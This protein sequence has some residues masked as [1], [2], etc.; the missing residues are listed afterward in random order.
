[1]IDKSVLLQVPPERAFELF[2][3]RISAWWPPDRRH[4]GDPASTL[5]LEP[6]GRF[7][8]RGG[9]GH[10]VELG[11]VVAW[12]PPE[13]LVLDFYPGTGPMQPTRVVVTFQPEAGGTRVRV[14]HTPGA[15][16]PALWEGRVALFRGG[17]DKV[18]AGISAFS[19]LA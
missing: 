19:S 9:D 14:V 8:E 4:T 17:W 7:W 11:R 5:T 15:C 3:R 10:E 12:T 18:L 6:T 16:D 2:T 13:R 1:M